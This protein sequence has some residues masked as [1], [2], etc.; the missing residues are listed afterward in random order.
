M[1]PQPVQ[2]TPEVAA[3]RAE[4]L[5]TKAVIEAKSAIPIAVAT[6]AIVAPSVPVVD[7]PEVSYKTGN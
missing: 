2:D 3:A 1:V 4:H 7:T 5:A 6:P